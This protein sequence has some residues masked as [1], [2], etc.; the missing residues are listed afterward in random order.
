M[1]TRSNVGAQSPINIA[2][3]WSPLRNKYSDTP[4]IVTHN[5]NKKILAPPIFLIKFIQYNMVKPLNY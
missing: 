4:M 5:A 1:T 3:N 2:C